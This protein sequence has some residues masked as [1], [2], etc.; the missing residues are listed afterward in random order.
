[1][2]IYTCI[3]N[4][5]YNNENIDLKDAFGRAEFEFESGQDWILVSKKE[6][7]EEQYSKLLGILK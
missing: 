4:G 2:K 7:T 3:P 1:M 6:L 5:D